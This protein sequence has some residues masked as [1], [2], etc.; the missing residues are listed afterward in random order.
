MLKE[1]CS[2]SGTG[3]A[4]CGHATIHK[5]GST[6]QERGIVGCKEAD[7]L[8]DFLRCSQPWNE[9]GAEKAVQGGG[10][11]IGILDDVEILAQQWRLDEIG[12]ASRRVRVCPYV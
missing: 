11:C 12:R 9:V 1:G 7:Q 8:A 10:S 5:I 4:S 3:A 6:R 2:L